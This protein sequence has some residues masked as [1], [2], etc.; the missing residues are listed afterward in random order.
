M[1]RSI[2][3]LAGLVVGGVTAVAVAQIPGENPFPAPVVKPV[4]VSTQTVTGPGSSLGEGTL[5]NFFPRGSTVVFRAFAGDVKTG[6]VLTKA[7]VK[8]FYVTIPGQPNV[9]L[10][11]RDD[12]RW[13][14]TGTWTVPADFATGLVQFRTLLRTHSKQVASFVQIPVA[15]SQL[16]VTAQ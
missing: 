2:A 15:T 16:T 9:K 1:R 10:S 13:P 4:F 14:W 3:I 5:T 8:F 12:K 7:D 6:K 11:Y